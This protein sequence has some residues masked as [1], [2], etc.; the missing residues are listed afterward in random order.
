MASTDSRI[1]V[2]VRKGSERNER[3]LSFIPPEEFTQTEL[4]DAG[5]A[6]DGNQALRS[7]TVSQLHSAETQLSDSFRQK[8][9][10]T[11]FC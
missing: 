4:M 6:M 1:Q 7:I 9:Y 2:Y 11:I 5:W 10:S 3:I 8:G